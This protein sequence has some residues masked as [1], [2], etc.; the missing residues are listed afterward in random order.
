MNVLFRRNKRRFIMQYAAF[1]E[2]I[3]HLLLSNI[4]F[5]TLQY[6]IYYSVI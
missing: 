6:I 1:Y 4:L 3:S 5:I 2:V